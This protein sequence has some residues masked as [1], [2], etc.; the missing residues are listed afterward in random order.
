[1]S[2]FFRSTARLLQSA[3]STAL[4]SPPARQRLTTNLTGLAVHPAPFHHLTELY[5]ATLTLLAQMPPS[6]VYRQSVESITKE[7][8]S[9]IELLGGGGGEKE[10]ESVEEKIG[11]G[12]I[13]EV[14]EMAQTELALAEKMLEWQPLVYLLLLLCSRE[15][16]RFTHSLFC[17]TA[18]LFI[19]MGGIDRTSRTRPMG[20]IQ[21]ASLY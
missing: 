16:D 18:R 10:I 5:S 19:Q 21:N 15:E 3:P 14:V 8:M 6:A 20:G 11:A 1:M 4:A 17:S 9:V 2:R 7:R 12:L 13:E